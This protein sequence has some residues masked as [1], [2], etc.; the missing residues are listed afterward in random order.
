MVIIP[1][2]DKTQNNNKYVE[3]ITQAK[4]TLKNIKHRNKNQNI[5]F[6]KNIHDFS[7]SYNIDKN[8]NNYVIYVVAH[9]EHLGKI[10][11]L[12]SPDGIKPFEF[13]DNLINIFFK[14]NL[15]KINKI[16]FYTCN[17]IYHEYDINKSYCGKVA[18]I[19]WNK[20]KFHNIIIGGFNGFL[21]EDRI[22]KRTYISNVFNCYKKKK[23][24]EDCIIYLQY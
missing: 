20:Y 11:Y 8:I 3:L 6:D 23:R 22:K 18:D 12:N 21:Y 15:H 24:A 9:H 4:I 13:V 7:E 10:G 14:N 16:I 1:I 17:S 5:I 19:L 2:C